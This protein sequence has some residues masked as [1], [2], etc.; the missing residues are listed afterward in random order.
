[1]KKI[2]SNLLWLVF[3]LWTGFSQVYWQL[4]PHIADYNNQSLHTSAYLII[5]G[6]TTIGPNVLVLLLGHFISRR[7]DT[8]SVVIKTWLNT[9]VFGIFISTI[10]AMSSNRLAKVTFFGS[11]FLDSMFP[12]IRNNYPLIFGPLFG[13]LLV[14]VIKRL[15]TKWQKR[16]TI[17]TWVLIAIPIFNYPNIWGWA[18][19][20]LVIFYAVL[21]VIGSRLWST[22]KVLLWP[23]LVALIIN[24]FLQGV[25][26]IFSIS[27][28]TITRYS[29]CTNVLTVFVAYV[30]SQ[31]TI[32]YVQKFDWQVLISF[33]VLIESSALIARILLPLKLGNHHSS[34]KIGI[35]TIAFLLVA[36]VVA[37]VW[38]LLLNIPYLKRIDRAIHEFTKNDLTNQLLKVKQWLKGQIPNI[39]LFALSYLIAAC[40][41]LLMNDGF[42]VSPNVDAT[43]NIFAYTFGTRELLILFAASLI[44]LTAK[45][46]QALTKRYWV[47]LILIV[48]I[49]ALIVVANRQKIAARNEPILPSDL[50]MIS[51][52]RDIFGMVS[53]GIWITALIVL[54]VLI[55]LC[56]WLE[57][58]HPIKEKWSLK[59][60]VLFYA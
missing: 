52:A 26:P 51:V 42:K 19:N 55:A 50:L 30:I 43:Y 5:R 6:L 20:Y 17:G 58:K 24:I 31:F 38:S 33:L 23:G 8:E 32:K 60:R 46:I 45:F 54:A 14:N 28:D 44:F 2:R 13:L 37:K 59:K 1:M 22:K 47:S 3:L 39:C 15:D 11:N 57:K 10:V 12:L 36:L 16:I 49:N 7:K 56:I 27:G 40:S 9:L 41:M 35:Y 21:F 48:V 25:M 34:L 29:D 18:D 4:G 53:I